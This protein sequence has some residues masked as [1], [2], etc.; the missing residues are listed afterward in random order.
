MCNDVDLKSLLKGPLVDFNDLRKGTLEKYKDI[1]LNAQERGVI[2]LGLPHKN[3]NTKDKSLYDIW[4]CYECSHI[5]CARTSTIKDGHG[6]SQCGIKKMAASLSIPLIEYYNQILEIHPEWDIHCFTESYN[7]K[8]LSRYYCYY[9]CIICNTDACTQ[10]HNI[11]QG[12]G[13][14]YCSSKETGKKLEIPLIDYILEIKEIHKDNLEILY[15]P[16]GQNINENRN[17]SIKLLCRCKECNAKNSAKIFNLKKG[18][19]IKCKCS[20]SKGEKEIRKVLEKYNIKFKSE[21]TFKETGLYKY[22]FY[23]DPL[24]V[25]V[26]FDGKQHF[27]FIP[28]WHKTLNGFAEQTSRDQR[29]DEFALKSGIKLIRIPYFQFDDIEEILVRELGL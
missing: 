16:P 15:I 2:S 3:T 29:K 20:D 8:K 7:S 14:N 26:E 1:V 25:L 22:D 10:I 12:G 21:K 5:W 4:Q 11:L 9:K 17:S 6:C 18:Q 19:T 28:Y 23:I 13:C 27:S 24:N